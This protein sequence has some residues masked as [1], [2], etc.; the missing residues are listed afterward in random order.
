MP[1]PRP[2]RLPQ[3]YHRLGS[4]TFLRPPTAFRLSVG[5][6]VKVVNV[7]DSP[8]ATNDWNWRACG[9]TGISTSCAS[10]T[11]LGLAL[12][13]DL[14]WA[15]W[16]SPGTLGLPAEGILTPLSLLMPTF[17]LDHAPRPV[18]LPLH[19]EIDAPLPRVIKTHPW[20]RYQ[21]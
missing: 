4:S 19:C 13:P 18:T 2:T 11:P 1:T 12:A 9:G 20:L 16:P 3:D 15:D 17:S 8:L 5:R 14:P 10:T 7:Q 21:T 6:F